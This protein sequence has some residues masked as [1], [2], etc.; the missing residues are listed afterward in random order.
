MNKRIFK[1]DELKIEKFLNRNTSIN[2]G[3]IRKNSS[4]MHISNDLADT[5]KSMLNKDHSKSN[6]PMY[7][8][9]EGYIER[10]KPIITDSESERHNV[11]VYEYNKILSLGTG[12]KF[13][14]I[15][16]SSSN[17]RRFVKLKLE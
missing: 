13:G 9:T 1:T 15:A 8:S 12:N 4:I 16:L 2:K 17:K 6:K 11:F 10:L 5:I 14:E 3:M 7:I